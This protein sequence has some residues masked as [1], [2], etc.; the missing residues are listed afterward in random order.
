MTTPQAIAPELDAPPPPVDLKSAVEALR[1]TID[2]S[3]LQMG[4]N[5]DPYLRIR[6]DTIAAKAVATY[7][8]EHGA[9][10]PTW[11]TQN[12]MQLRRERRESSN[13]IRVPE[14]VQ[15][16]S[17]ALAKATAE[18]LDQHGRE[19]NILELADATHLPPRRIEHVR[20]HEVPTANAAAFGENSSAVTTPSY[21]KEALDYVYAEADPVDRKILEMRMGYGGKYPTM[22][23]KRDIAAA[24]KL[25]PA[26]VSR[27]SLQLA[28]RIERM[29]QAIANL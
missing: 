19:P 10:L 11:V 13:S 20:A 7:K 28:L 29:K 21:D 14:R 9:S 27:R 6:A 22:A 4:A 17:F 5:D 23:S 25:H 18:F 3:L 26:Q 8:P 1:P 16:D 15:L 12:L 24:V 2:Y